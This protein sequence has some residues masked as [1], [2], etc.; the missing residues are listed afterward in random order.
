[1]VQ[2][3]MKFGL[4]DRTLILVV[5]VF[6]CG[7]A[8][9]GQEKTKRVFLSPKST[10]TTSEVAEGFQKSCPNVVLTQNEAKADYVLEA[11]ETTSAYEGS[12]SRHWHFTLFNPDGDVLLT[13]HPEMHFAHKFKHHFEAVCQFINGRG[14]TG[15]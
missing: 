4:K 3:R 7:T 12:T 5:L 9:L 11:A 13:T 6:I 8:L 2:S 1:M 15:K 10:I 14:A